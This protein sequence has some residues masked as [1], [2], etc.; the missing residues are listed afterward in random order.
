MLPHSFTLLTKFF[1][2]IWAHEDRQNKLKGGLPPPLNIYLKF[3]YYKTNS[4]ISYTLALSVAP[5]S[6]SFTV[7]TL[8]LAFVAPVPLPKLKRPTRQ[9]APSQLLQHGKNHPSAIV[10]H[11]Y[12]CFVHRNTDFSHLYDAAA[13]WESRELHKNNF[14]LPLLAVVISVVNTHQCSNG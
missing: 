4:I 1:V 13:Q 3:T 12:F 7:F 9:A 8:R 5:Y 6:G 2:H 10:L 11:S 14:F